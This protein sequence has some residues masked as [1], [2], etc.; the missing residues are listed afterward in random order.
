MTS[1]MDLCKKN[2]IRPLAPPKSEGS[3]WS[4]DYWMIYC[5]LYWYP[6]LTSWMCLAVF[7]IWIRIRIR[8]SE[9]FW[10][11]P[12]PDPLFHGSRWIQVTS[13][14]FIE[15]LT[16]FWVFYFFEAWK[17]VKR[18]KCY[19]FLHGIQIFDPKILSSD[20]LKLRRASYFF[21]CPIKTS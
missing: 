4:H 3:I 13:D 1:G 12:D 21:S 7:R 19:D 5:R 15:F 6:Y 20:W 17:S 10:L 14:I 8:G 2:T 16:K 11:D 9:A 18:F